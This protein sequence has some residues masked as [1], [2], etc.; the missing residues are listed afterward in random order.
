MTS[1]GIQQ[2]KLHVPPS[3]ILIPARPHVIVTWS[4]IWKILIDSFPLNQSGEASLL[5]G[6]VR[7]TPPLP[8]TCQAA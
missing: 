3:C 2:L 6:D 5:V 7:A 4:M 8:S 1:W